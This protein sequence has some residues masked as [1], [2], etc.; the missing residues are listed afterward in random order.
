MTP[1]DSKLFHLD[2]LLGFVCEDLQ[3]SPSQHERARSAYETIA[4]LLA[5]PD[6]LVARFDPDVYAQGS[7]AL[8]TTVK[9]REGEEFDVDLVCALRNLKGRRPSRDDLIA[10]IAEQLRSDATYAPRV[11]VRDR[12]VRVEYAGDFHV[13]VVPAVPAPLACEWGERAIVIPDRTEQRWVATNPAGFKRWFFQQ[14]RIGGAPLK[15]EARASV[16]PFPHRV[17]S[18]NKELLQREAQLFKRRR[19]VQFEGD[20]DRG[21][22]SILLATMNGQEYL[23]QSSPTVAIEACLAS[24]AA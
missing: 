10:L 23:G 7:M 12:C 19:D 6:G 24:V 3:L 21:P 14:S 11:K 16:E 9:P 22:K 15:L 2:L 17:E 4:G 20:G 13:D 1:A 18:A 8:L 5:N